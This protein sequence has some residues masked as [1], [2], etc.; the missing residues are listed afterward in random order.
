MYVCMYVYVCMAETTAVGIEGGKVVFD[1]AID[2]IHA[3]SSELFRKLICRNTCVS[4]VCAMCCMCYVL[5]AM[6][7]YVHSINLQ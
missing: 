3:Q 1:E 5:C 6:Y 2:V 4:D 7:V